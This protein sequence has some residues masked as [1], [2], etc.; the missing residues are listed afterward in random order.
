MKKPAKSNKPSG[1]RR[2]AKSGG[3]PATAAEV[4]GPAPN[5]A[6]PIKRV[7]AKWRWHYRVLVSL[8]DR[9][10][11]DRGNLLRVAAE[12]LEPHSLDDA[13]SATDEFDHD[14]ALAQLSAEQDALYE[15]NEAL[16]RILDGTYGVC[17]KTGEAIPAS[18]LKAVPWTRFTWQIKDR[19]EKSGDAP[20]TRLNKAAT[21]R[22]GGKFSFSPGEEEG[23]E[24]AER[25]APP[26]T[27]ISRRGNS[28]CHRKAGKR[29]QQR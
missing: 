5:S 29:K 22:G 3:R 10:L 13:D 17:E 2:I 8:Q 28:P 23:E 6:F 25:K 26:P 19:L 20:R 14:L 7:P 21:V 12:P 15:I 18:R 1:P 4:L 16:N 24:V 9:L 11:G 27:A